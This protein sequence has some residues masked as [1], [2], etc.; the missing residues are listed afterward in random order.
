MFHVSQFI[1]FLISE[2][3]YGANTAYYGTLPPESGAATYNQT[4][5]CLYSEAYEYSH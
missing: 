5:L 3:Q 2:R 4:H 1:G